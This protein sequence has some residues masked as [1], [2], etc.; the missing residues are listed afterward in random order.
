[1]NQLTNYKNIVP[2]AGVIILNLFYLLLLTACHNKTYIQIISDE[3]SMEQKKPAHHTID[4]FTNLYAPPVT[5]GPFGYWKMRLFGNEDFA[6]HEENSHLIAIADS[7]LDSIEKGEPAEVKVTW[8]GHST[9]LIQHQNISIL[10]DPIFSDR[11]SPLSF[12]GPKRLVPLPIKFKDLPPIDFIIISHNH[13]DHL[14]LET[15][16]LFGNNTQFIVPLKLKAWFIEQGISTE[17]IS[18]FDWWDTAVFDELTITATP[19]QHW[20]A[21]TLFDRNKTLWASWHLQI[22]DFSIWFAGDTGYNDIQFKEIG[23]HFQKID[24][25]LIPIGAY[26]PRWFMKQQHVNPAEAV[27]IHEDVKSKQS[28]GMHWGTFQLTAEEIDAPKKEL[29]VALKTRNISNEDFQTLAIGETFRY[30]V[31]KTIKIHDH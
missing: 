19:S 10:T 3:S 26:A 21:R 8:I 2:R 30:K 18:E 1:M 24:L 7:N 15:I 5:K 27:L 23:D 25:S 14:D 31:T 9:F 11:A 4:G 6:E 22:K 12:A 28:I 13:Y 29:E 16:K 17:K 20:S